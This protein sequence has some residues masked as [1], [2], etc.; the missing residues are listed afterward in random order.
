MYVY[1]QTFIHTYRQ[2]NKLNGCMSHT[3]TAKKKKKSHGT[4]NPCLGVKHRLTNL[5]LLDL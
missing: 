2:T 4:D 1:I 3:C 5:Y